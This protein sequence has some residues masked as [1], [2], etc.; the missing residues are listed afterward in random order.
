MVQCRKYAPKLL[1][2]IL[3]LSLFIYSIQFIFTKPQKWRSQSFTV[4]P[5]KVELSKS[6]IQEAVD[7]WIQA[8]VKQTWPN[9]NVKSDNF[10]TFKKEGPM[11]TDRFAPQVKS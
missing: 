4:A 10:A 2:C 11:L 6:F 8:V 1:K 7:P 5:T 3:I 9:A